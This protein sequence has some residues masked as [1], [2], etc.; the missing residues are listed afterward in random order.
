MHNPINILFIGSVYFGL[1]EH[2]WIFR[3]EIKQKGT[4]LNKYLLFPS[5]YL[6]PLHINPQPTVSTNKEKSFIF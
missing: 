6:S 3:L 4:I 5:P 1:Y 2:K